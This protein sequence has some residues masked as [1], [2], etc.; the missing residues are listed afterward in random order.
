MPA[1]LRLLLVTLLLF[2]P[3]SFLHSQT[4]LRDFKGSGQRLALIEL[5]NESAEP[6]IVEGLKREL[7]EELRRYSEVF[8]D[9]Q[10]RNFRLL[11]NPGNQYFKPASGRFQEIQREF[12]VRTGQDNSVDVLVLGGVRESF[13]GIE[14][15]LQLFDV[16][17]QEASSVELEVFGLRDRRQRLQSLVHR[18]L[19][20]MDRDGFVNPQP[21]DFLERPAH[22]EDSRAAGASIFDSDSFVRPE[23]LAPGFLED[24]RSIGG[25]R[26]PFWE[27]WWFWTII[28]GGL[29][30]AGGLTYYFVVVDQPANQGTIDFKLP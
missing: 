2:L 14:V 28:G 10:T 7:I 27:K 6:S 30:T 12:L 23:D 13:E 22:L 24:D 21:Q 8:D 17:I 25:D 18:T 5:Y 4:S 16:R 9:N 26:T 29:V 15:S 20:Y 3:P 11:D 1:F 19:N